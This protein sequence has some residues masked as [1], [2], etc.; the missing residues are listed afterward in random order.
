MTRADLDKKPAEVAAM[1]DGLAG[2]YDLMIQR[3]PLG[4]ALRLC[5]LFLGIWIAGDWVGARRAPVIDLQAVG[6]ILA[7]CG[8]CLTLV[9]GYVVV[10]GWQLR[11]PR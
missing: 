7:T 4:T 3:V 11:H 9:S 6:G 5:G 10:R 2:R 8:C 1:F